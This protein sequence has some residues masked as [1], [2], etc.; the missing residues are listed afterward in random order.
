MPTDNLQNGE[1]PKKKRLFFLMAGKSCPLDFNSVLVYSFLIYRY[2]L[3]NGMQQDAAVTRQQIHLG[4][5]LCATRTIPTALEQ[6]EQHGLIGL[7]DNRV[8]PFQPKQDWFV[9]YRNGGLKPWFARIAYFPIWIPAS[10]K[11]SGLV[12]RVN[13]LFFLIKHKPNQ[14]QSYY[15]A[16]LGVSLTT[17]RTAI[18]TLRRLKLLSVSELRGR[19]LAGD[20]WQLWQDK[21]KRTQTTVR[22]WRLSQSDLFQRIGARLENGKFLY[23]FQIE[24][25]PRQTF[26]RIVDWFGNK[27]AARGYSRTEIESY[28]SDVAQRF[29]IDESD[30]SLH[31]FELFLWLNFL[32]VFNHAE[33][34][35][36]QSA[37]AGI[38]SGTNSLGLLKRI[39]SEAVSQINTA[40][41]NHAHYGMG[42]CNHQWQAR[43]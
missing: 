29:L 7:V 26:D 38:F 5:G 15:A 19:D 31:K 42:T 2:K 32:D 16:K 10:A 9:Q 39:T 6:L 27:M 17:V 1:E 18:K 14:T 43:T 12:P 34:I 35:T 23:F 22:R 20:Q 11:S 13:A 41:D 3:K 28:W 4:T 30:A 33:K 40:W 25:E 36:L 21:K 8:F 37:S 24:E